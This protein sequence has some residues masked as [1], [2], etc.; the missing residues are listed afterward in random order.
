MPGTTA[1]PCVVAAWLTGKIDV[2]ALSAAL[3]DVVADH[4]V[5]R[6]VCLNTESGPVLRTADGTEGRLRVVDVAAAD[7][8]QR[9]A[10]ARA[11][12]RE[13]VG[14][15]YA[16]DRGPL[17]RAVLFAIG[18]TEHLFAWVLHGLI[19]DHES[20]PILA[21]AL[22][23]RYAR[24]R[25]EEAPEN[26][27]RYVDFVA[28]PPSPLAGPTLRDYWRD[29]LRDLPAMDVPTDRP[30]PVDP[31]LAADRAEEA[32]P[33]E[34]VAAAG[35]MSG[36]SYPVYLAALFEL[37]R[38]HTGQRDLV[39]GCPIARRTDGEAG[40][41]VGQCTNLVPIRVVV[42][43]DES[44]A[45]LVTRVDAAVTE[46]RAH[47]DLPFTRMVAAVEP[48]REPGRVPLVPL[49]LAPPGRP[50][51]LNLPGVAARAECIPPSAVAHDLVWSVDE[52]EGRSSVAIDY[53]RDLFDADTV[54]G[55]LTHLVRLIAEALGDPDRPL[56]R[57]T[58]MSSDEHHEL[59]RRWNGPSR[60]VAETTIDEWFARVVARSPDAVAV[61][62]GEERL[63]Y[64][65]LDVA[66]NR[67][68][69][70]LRG[71]GIGAGVRVGLCLPRGTSHVVAVLA[72]L[73]VGAAFVPIDPAN[74]SERIA[75]LMHEARPAM[76][77][78]VSG[79]EVGRWGAG[80]SLLR[81]DAIAGELAGQRDDRPPPA[82]APHHLAY[83]LYTSGSTGTPKGVMIEHRNVV[84]FIGSV[85]ELFDLG[86]A[87]RILG[88]AAYGFDVSVFEMLAALLTGARLH[89]ALDV[90]R[91]DPDLL[92]RLLLVSGVTVID[93]PPSIM[94]LLDP[95]EL[96]TLRI[97]FVGGEAFSGD[98]VNRWNRVS[99]FFNGYGPTECTV[100][101]I[102]QE[103]AGWWSGSPPIG[104]PMAN[105]VAHV[106]DPDFNLVP[107][108]VPGELVI[109]GAGLAAGYLGDEALTRAKFLVDPFG[110]A[111]GGRLY[112]TGD[113]VKR[114]RDGA[115]VFLGRVD[116]Q[117]K[118]RGVRVE[119]G[120]IEAALLAQ[121][122]VRQ[123]HVEARTGRKDQPYLV[124]YVG[125]PA[126]PLPS[127]AGLR[128]AISTRLPAGLVPQ[129]VVVLPQL[130]L[131][132]SGKID[133]RRLPALP[134]AGEGPAARAVALTPTETVIVQELAG[135]LLRTPAV[136]PGADFFASG[137]TSMQAVALVDAVAR[138][139]EVEL[140]LVEFLRDPTIAR[141]GR[142]V[143]DELAVAWTQ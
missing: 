15:P 28:R 40:V 63:T 27:R 13:L 116:R 35:A 17:W 20:A 131:T 1:Q 75:Q 56:H 6:T 48:V 96:S 122:G 101:M 81:L 5:L 134:V 130:P 69:W 89:V 32:L 123:A 38:R 68:A 44:F 25:V 4:D 43:P 10:Q 82:S 59:L 52:G 106:V 33:A 46:A 125:A 53:R 22:S 83:V 61:V 29:R 12:A 141:L 91:L 36:S 140:P 79:T 60:V 97:S 11:L 92:Q 67:L 102:V 26:R 115:L 118:V 138:R 72:A 129:Q 58:M 76:V 77:I 64:A 108:G 113:L 3:D 65:Q 124:A 66:A 21:A 14:A 86:P 94:S 24:R 51:G 18:P 128:A 2:G 126:S 70:L 71:R 39:V 54:A 105:H 7:P 95:S 80:T 111:P 30:R 87:D 41:L 117:V 88:Y 8:G 121:P 112:R 9:V 47:S 99:R 107:Y 132:A 98:L 34:L 104:L 45:R 114:R 16:L 133:R 50:V 110:T 139:F 143:D 84:N 31:R 119:L 62:A 90:D 136:D 137:G 127:A 49:V 78:T 109:G 73:K 23:D 55:F 19:A 57:L 100:T 37:L 120:E 74:P 42:D 93:L 142:L 135:R 103:C 85:K